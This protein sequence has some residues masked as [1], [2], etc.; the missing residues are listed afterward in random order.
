MTAV[1]RPRTHPAPSAEGTPGHAGNAEDT[2]PASGPAREEELRRVAAAVPDP[3]LP[4][5]GLGDLGVLRSVQLSPD[6]VRAEVE[7]TPTYSGC[8]AVEAMATDV[9]SALREAGVPEVRVRTVL[10][11]PWSTD[12]ITPA[13]RRALA[14]AG[15]APPRPGG[16][17]GGAADGPVPVELAIRCPRCGSTATTLMSR[18]SATPCTSLRRCESCREPFD[19]VKEL[20]HVPRAAG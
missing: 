14:D 3:E 10:S 4:V 2:T 12:D 19:H 6:G 9:E 15:L 18:F 17:T 16:P 1:D 11:P 5:I 8:P 7:I 20:I 13:G